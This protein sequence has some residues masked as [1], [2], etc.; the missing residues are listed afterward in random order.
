[1]FGTIVSFK[2]LKKTRE[3]EST[4]VMVNY[5]S[6]S[7]AALAIQSLNGQMLQDGERPLIVKPASGPRDSKE[8]VEPNYFQHPPP[9]GFLPPAS[10]VQPQAGLPT[11]SDNLWVG[12]LPMNFSESDVNTLFSLYR[13][14]MQSKVLKPR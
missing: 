5:S 6:P 9:I 14:V 2:I 13:N 1:M 11:P 12:N 10:V 7:Q 8:A 4:A 3:T